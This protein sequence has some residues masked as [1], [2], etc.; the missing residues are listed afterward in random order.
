MR[1]LFL[2]NSIKSLQNTLAE[3][4]PRHYVGGDVDVVN[5]AHRLLE[6]SLCDLDPDPI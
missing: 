2:L 5:P 6:R 1:S 4:S 3:K